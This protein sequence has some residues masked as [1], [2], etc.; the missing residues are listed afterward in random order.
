MAATIL[1]IEDNDALRE[2]LAAALEQRGYS[3]VH[4]TSAHEALDRLRASAA[5]DLL[6]VDLEIPGRDDHALIAENRRYAQ[7][8][9]KLYISGFPLIDAQERYDFPSEASFL[10][11]PFG[12]AEFLATVR[13]L[14]AAPA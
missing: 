2:I 8:I 4:A 12:V 3:V 5:F 10:A 13:A 1:F 14:V 9:P 11:K 6:I 7:G